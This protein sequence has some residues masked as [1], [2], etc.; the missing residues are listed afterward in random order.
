MTLIRMVLRKMLKNRIFVLFLVIGLLIS[1]GLMS[2]IPIYTQ[3]ALQK[4]LIKQL[5]DS[6][7]NGKGYPGTYMVTFSDSDEKIDTALSDIGKLN[8]SMFEYDTVKSL[9]NKRL[10]TFNSINKYCTEKIKGKL[11]IPVQAQITE[12]DTDS[13]PLVH[14]GFKKG[15]N[16]EGQYANIVSL[17]D[18]NNHIKLIDGRLPSKTSDGVYEVLVSQFA[19]NSLN[20]AINRVYV[21]S[22]A[23]Q[24]GFNDIKVKPVGV[25]DIKNESDIYWQFEKPDSLDKC[26]VMDQTIMSNSMIEKNPTLIKKA[27]WFYALDYHKINLSNLGRFSSGSKDINN[28]IY[29]ISQNISINAP[30]INVIGSYYDQESSIIN[31]MWSL[32]VPV[33]IILCLYLF[34]VSSLIID[35]EKNEISLLAS[36]G[37]SRLQ[38]VF[39]YFIEGAILG[40][41]TL[42]V[43]P[44]IGLFMTK[45]LG[46]SNGFLEFVDR[47]PLDVTIRFDCYFYVLLAIAVFIVTLLIP[48]YNAN[49]T[50]I[51]DHKRKQGRRSGRTIWQKFYLDFLL[52]GIS[53]YE[54]FY[55][56][57]DIQSASSGGMQLSPV[58]L[59]T[60][61]I[62]II[63]ISLLFLRIYPYIIKVIYWLGKKVWPPS[64]YA[65]LTQ[66]GRAT[67]SY[68]FLMVFLMLTISVG[69]FSATTARTINS[70]ITDNIMYTNGAD[71]TI[72]NTWDMRNPPNPIQPAPTV[73]ENGIVS[74]G[75]IEYYEPDYTPYT[76]LAGVEHTAKVFM[77]DK[78]SIILDNGSDSDINVMGI[79]PYDFGQVAWYRNDLFKPYH[80]N[81]YLNLLS[82]ESSSCLISRDISN[83]NGIKL[84]DSISVSY[85][86]HEPVV[87]NVYGIIDNWPTMDKKDNSKLIVANLSYLQ[88][89]YGP[90]PYQ[91]WLKLKPNATSQQVYN[92][93]TA[94]KIYPTKVIDSKQEIIKAK[95]DPTQLAINGT[96]TMGFLIS[97]LI[98]FMG[99]VLYWILS[100]KSRV[101]QFGVMR[102][103][104]LSSLQLKLMILWEQLLTSG[105][106]MIMGVTIGIFTGNVFVQPYE[107]VFDPATQ[108]IPFMVISAS[109]DR[110]KVY[111]FICFTVLLGLAVLI[112]M[113]SKI[114]ISNVIKLGED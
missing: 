55:G 108:V 65:A 6:Q 46:A 81:S 29:S 78:A 25:F 98:C 35:R 62:F 8:K 114:K 32:N 105:V 110:L 64:I 76:K 15:D 5:E 34:M 91:V 16:S 60:P 80:I 68:G 89:T 3:G 97:G 113:L 24:N 70:N 93:L 90:E 104:G 7:A 42:I 14:E 44:F 1:S 23:R 87:L 38:V 86:S 11:G 31:M 30:A 9:Y 103:M 10:Q 33:I 100:L 109:G 49:K 26:F 75:N 37:A 50:S 17:S 52:I 92:S 45:I 63:G 77:Q 111:A 53:A 21:L 41:V 99:F 74:V 43:G 83:K 69:L 88:D 36:R 72:Q 106:A 18:F 107:K 13:R 112:Y 61:I 66:V 57:K 59:I 96:M 56:F 40:F 47:K 67:N 39:E 71:I 95:N 27:K 85:N 73:D 58:L 51:V 82:S 102:A 22:D 2:S 79:D 28:D 4:V 101:L 48:A 19:V 12:Y 94:N 84:G 20:I 54:Y